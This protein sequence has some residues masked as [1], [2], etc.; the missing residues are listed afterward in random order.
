MFRNIMLCLIIASSCGCMMSYRD[1]VNI[2]G[3]IKNERYT[4]PNSVFSCQ[5]P[6]LVRPGARIEDDVSPD[7]AACN[8]YFQDDL[9]TWINIVC[10]PSPPNDK[11]ANFIERYIG[12]DKTERLHRESIETDGEEMVYAIVKV[13]EGSNM[14]EASK[15][16]YDLIEGVLIFERNNHLYRLIE[17]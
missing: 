16:R 14:V 2:E 9:G 3:N 15:G 1:H 10:I 8:V 17:G 11:Q 7:G 13:P 5:V 4:S 12:D 6:R